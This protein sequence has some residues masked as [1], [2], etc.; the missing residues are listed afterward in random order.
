M[1]AFFKIA[2]AWGISSAD[3]ATLLGV[4]TKTVSRWEFKVETLSRDTRERVGYVL[5]IYGCLCSIFDSADSANTW[6]HAENAD[7]GGASPLSRML[8]GNV[9][10]LFTTFTYVNNWL[11]GIW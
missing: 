6:I 11:N 10:D 8:A 5:G 2:D 1:R 4:S 7:F 9:G 3:A